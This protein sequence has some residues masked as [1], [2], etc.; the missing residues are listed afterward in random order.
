[1][2]ICL[3]TWYDE[4]IKDYADINYEINDRYAEKY[5]YK[6]I[7][8]SKSRLKNK[9]P[10]WEKLPFILSLMENKYDY[11]VWIDADAF[12]YED[13][14]PIEYV[15]NEHQQ[16]NFIFSGDFQINYHPAN[17]GINLVNVNCGIFIVKNTNYS[18]NIIKEWYSNDYPIINPVWWEQ[19]NLMHMY[20]NNLFNLQNNS[21]IIPYN[22]LQHFKKEHLKYCITYKYGL[23]NKPF[24]FHMAGETTENRIKY[25]SEYFNNT[26]DNQ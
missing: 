23:K 14:P 25:S 16:S 24:I 15:I 1:M 17:I 18:K 3:A 5:N 11:I 22:I 4:N 6:F 19:N 21:I 9:E 10:S 2:N 7:K 12:F 8:C 26:F 20:K 13:S